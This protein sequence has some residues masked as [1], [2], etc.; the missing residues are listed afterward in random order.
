VGSERRLGGLLHARRPR[1]GTAIQE[2]IPYRFAKDGQINIRH[3]RTIY[4]QIKVV[5]AMP[6]ILGGRPV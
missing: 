6:P 1:N 3:R 5:N 2:P 4:K